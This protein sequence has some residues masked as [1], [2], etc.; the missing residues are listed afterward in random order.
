MKY[1]ILFSGA[2]L[3][4]LVAGFSGLAESAD[5]SEPIEIVVQPG[6]TLWQIANKYYDERFD[7]RLIIAHIKTHNDLA[8]STIHPGETLQLPRY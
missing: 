4:L 6:D 2:V 5:H 1:V 8:G 3:M 7:T